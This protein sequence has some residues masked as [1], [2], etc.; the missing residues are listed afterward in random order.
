MRSHPLGEQSLDN[1]IFALI[2]DFQHSTNIKF[3]CNIQSQRMS[4]DIDTAIYRIIQESVTN[5]CKHAQATE[6]KLRLTVTA[7]ALHLLIHDNGIGFN[8]SQNT[9]GFGLQSMRDRT[10]AIGGDLHI[11]SSPGQGCKIEIEISRFGL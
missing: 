8:L 1:A 11:E 2:E 3:D 9:T 7:T 4:D 6:V 10:L 5:I